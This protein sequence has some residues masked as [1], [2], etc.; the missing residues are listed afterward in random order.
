MAYFL[1]LQPLQIEGTDEDNSRLVIKLA[2]NGQV[3]TLSQFNA[4][5]V[6]K[7]EYKKYAKDLGKL[8]LQV[9]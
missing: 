5:A 9:G 2:I 3:I 7:S 4:Q 8:Y 6:S 1:T